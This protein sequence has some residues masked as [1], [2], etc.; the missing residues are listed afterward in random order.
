VDAST[1]LGVALPVPDPDE[2]AATATSTGTASRKLSRL[3]AEATT[4]ER[5]ANDLTVT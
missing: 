2:Q 4:G 3:L 5:R 1:G